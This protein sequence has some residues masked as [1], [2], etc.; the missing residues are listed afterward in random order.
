VKKLMEK[1]SASSAI[2]VKEFNKTLIYFADQ[3]KIPS[4]SK[5]ELER[6]DVELLEVNH[7]YYRG[8]LHKNMY[9]L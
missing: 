2:R 1:L 7:V 8:D 5:E 4:V 3:D 9:H 6:M